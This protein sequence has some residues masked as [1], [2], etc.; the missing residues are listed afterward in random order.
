MKDF[1]KKKFLI[2]SGYFA[3]R[4][5]RYLN[6]MNIILTILIKALALKATAKKFWHWEISRWCYI[7]SFLD[8]HELSNLVKE[9]TCFKNMQNLTCRELR[10]PSPIRKNEQ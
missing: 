7:E 8:E 9:K 6:M 10:L 5:I 4:I 2:K 1:L 3:E